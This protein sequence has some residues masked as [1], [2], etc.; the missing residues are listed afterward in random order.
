MRRRR[1]PVHAALVAGALVVLTAAA[2]PALA[3]L[4]YRYPLIGPHGY[5]HLDDTGF[6]K[7]R[8]NGS[9]H[10]GQDILADCGTPLVAVHAARVLA[11]GYSSGYGFYVVLGGKGTR[12]DFV[13]GHMRGRSRIG[14]RGTVKAGQRIGSVGQTGSDS[15]VCHLHFELWSGGWFKGGHRIDPLPHL[16]A[17]N[18]HSGGPVEEPKPKQKPEP[19]P[20]PGPGPPPQP[21]PPS[22]PVP[23]GLPIIGR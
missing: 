9:H 12:F 8:S 19:E 2:G 23:P 14:R 20:Q 1:L 16:R 21:P 6:G 11:A 15:G 3:R 18:K 5:G 10:T 4:S 17:W 7:K 13:Y 22:R